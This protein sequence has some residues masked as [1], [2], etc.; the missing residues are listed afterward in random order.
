MSVTCRRRRLHSM[1]TPERGHELP[2]EDEASPRKWFLPLP[3]LM[4]SDLVL[5]CGRTQTTESIG[6]Q[7]KILTWVS[8]GETRGK[9]EN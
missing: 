4:G 9:K 3:G 6:D 8:I 7:P 5:G 2:V 1:A